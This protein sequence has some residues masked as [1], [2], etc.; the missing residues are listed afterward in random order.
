MQP[1]LKS[2]VRFGM[3]L[4]DGSELHGYIPL[5]RNGVCVSTAVLFR[6]VLHFAF[7][8]DVF[9][10]V[11]TKRDGKLRHV[12]NFLRSWICVAISALSGREPK[13]GTATVFQFQR[14]KLE[15]GKLAL[16]G[17]N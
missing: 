4:G 5:L 15:S 11:A 14:G 10:F 13:I 17:A 9:C 8:W 1:G 6:N 12:I 2:S 16:I 7:S 3:T